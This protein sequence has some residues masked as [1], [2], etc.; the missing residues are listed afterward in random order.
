MKITCIVACDTKILP[1]A[2]TKAGPS[3]C[4]AAL[5]FNHV[6]FGGGAPFGGL[7][8]ISARPPISTLTDDGGRENCFLMTG[9][10]FIKYLINIDFI[11]R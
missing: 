3:A 11:L 2:V 6:I 5:F 7:Q 8:W 10:K 1:S 4:R 9:K